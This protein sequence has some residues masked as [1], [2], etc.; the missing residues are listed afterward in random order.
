MNPDDLQRGLEAD[1]A[2]SPDDLA[3]HAAYA[4]LLMER[5]DPRGE[6]IQVQLALED[7]SL[8]DADHQRL[9]RREQ[10]LLEAHQNEWLGRLAPHLSDAEFHFR[11]GWLNQLAL[12]NLSLPLA[13]ALRDAPEARLLRDL[14]MED[15]RADD[16]I[17]PEPDDNIPEGEVHGF[18]PVV[19]S[20]TLANLRRLQIGSDDGDDYNEYR[21][22]LYTS[23][24]PVLV[25][26]CPRLEEL[27]IFADEYSMIDLLAAPTLTRLRTL[28]IHHRSAVYRL[29]ILANNP[30]FHHLTHLLLH[31][32]CLAWHRNGEEDEAAGFRSEEGYLPLAVVK[33]LLHS[34]HVPN[35]THLRLRVSSMGDEGC[36]EI[37]RS[38]SLKRLKLLDLRH[39]RISDEGARILAECPDIRHLEMLDLSYNALSDNGV[40]QIEQLGIPARV[41]C[42]HAPDSRS[43]DDYLEEGEFE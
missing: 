9:K 28:Q 13:R 33:P 25:R 27:L 6:F 14:T 12:N 43:A 35:L 30:A 26:S 37:V 23:V 20:P 24:V 16:Q 38:G 1:L 17:P 15:A 11:R 4:D 22:W 34:P 10:E 5:G 32:H 7:K 18:W 31:P 29:D 42:Q 3:T 40:S 8:S 41:E 39:G 21:C 19:G 36:A 2:D